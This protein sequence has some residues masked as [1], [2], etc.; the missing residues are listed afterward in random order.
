MHRW[1]KTLTTCLLQIFVRFET[2]EQALE[3]LRALSGR[4]FADR[5]VVTSFLD[6]E[7]YNNDAF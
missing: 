4:K 6:E 5:T 7:S 2:P 1:K 3:G